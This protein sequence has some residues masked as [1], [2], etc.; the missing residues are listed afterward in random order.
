MYTQVIQSVFFWAGLVV[1]GAWLTVELLN[2]W[3]HY[4]IHSAARTRLGLDERPGQSAWEDRIKLQAAVA[5][6]DPDAGRSI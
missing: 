6:D 5:G 1:V 3:D 2:A 4:R